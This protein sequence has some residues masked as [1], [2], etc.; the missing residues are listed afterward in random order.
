MLKSLNI[1]LLL[2]VLSGSQLYAQQKSLEEILAMPTDQQKVKYM[3]SYAG[4]NIRKNPILAD[5]VCNLAITI[6]EREKY[7]YYLGKCYQVKGIGF[8]LKEDFPSS[9]L[10][11]EKAKVY[12]QKIDSVFHLQRINFNMGVNYYK[13]SE[14]RKSDSLFSIALK[15][16]E[17]NNDTDLQCQVLKSFSTSRRL[18]TQ[19]NDALKY[20]LKSAGLR[21]KIKDSLGLIMDYQ[22]IANILLELKRYENANDYFYKCLSL[23]QQTGN[24]INEE[25]I[26]P[27]IGEAYLGLKMYDKSR[28]AYMKALQVAKPNSV[29]H[30]ASVYTGLADLYYETGNTDSAFYY[31]NKSLA[32]SYS[33]N[34]LNSVASNYGNFAK[35]YYD[36]QEYSKCEVNLDSCE[37]YAIKCQDKK[38]L[39]FIPEMKSKLK[40]KNNDT[41]NAF[42]ELQKSV[43]IKDS[44]YNI[45]TT[46][47]LNE[48]L[49]KYETEKKE[50]EITKLNSEKLLDA[51]KL[52]RQKTLNFSLIIIAGLILIS[53]IL[54]FRNVQKKRNAEKQVA[55]LEKQNAIESMRSKIASDVHDDMGA[56]LTRLGLN[57]QQ[58]LSSTTISEREKQLAEKIATQS[59]DVI[60]GMREIIWASNPANDNLKSMLGFMRQYIDRFFDGTEIRPVVNFPHDVGEITLHPEVRRNLFL[61][62]KESLNNAVKY[63]GSDK[64]DIDFS[65][66]NENFNLNIKDYGKG[67]DD[68][69]KDDFSNGLNNMQMRAEQIKSLFKLITSPGKGVQIAIEGK[70]Y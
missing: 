42:S 70:L 55:I 38:M 45:E 57:A 48:L 25:A 47:Q 19:L 13:M 61:I 12:F 6:C 35:W 68:K 22:G 17:T 53:G 23:N 33:T 67:M 14:Y 11:F 28:H 43:A 3:V 58:L 59:K 37:Y 46:T 40:A 1:F 10:W 31:G 8:Q 7:D 20:A 15:F 29:M 64:V 9:F 21:E 60:T 30:F 65:N 63:S 41:K 51:E 62:L 18:R 32:H 52:S 54:I 26:Y 4:K 56:N 2:L 69:T 34:N 44:I 49:T 50:N 39:A 66:K 36:L 27:G 24:M 16:A 5:S